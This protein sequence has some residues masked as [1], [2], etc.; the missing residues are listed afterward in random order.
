MRQLRLF[1]DSDGFLRCGGRIHKALLD[2]V[3]KFPFLLPLKHPVTEL[4]VHD[5]HQKQLHS[6]VNNTVTAI[7]QT[8]WITCIR[9]YV[10]KLL[11]NCLT[12]RKL[13]GTVFKAQ[14]PAPLPK[15]RT[16]EKAPF[17]ET[18]VDFTSPINV[19]S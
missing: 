17:T 10:R 8:F 5:V 9:Q 4:I 1:L 12:C 15:L 11:R 14:D 18:G 2:D 19:Q 7:R 3:T 13:E 16:Q 6:G